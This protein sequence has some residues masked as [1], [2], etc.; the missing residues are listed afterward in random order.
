MV[1]N[2]NSNV[3]PVV[4]NIVGVVG[5]P[6]V[7]AIGLLFDSLKLAMLMYNGDV[8]VTKKQAVGLLSNLEL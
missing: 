8:P 5:N 1:I 6:E 2:S 3:I 4:R 7:I